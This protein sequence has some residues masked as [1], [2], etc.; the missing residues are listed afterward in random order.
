MRRRSV[1]TALA[2]G[3]LCR[4]LPLDAKAQPA[5]PSQAVRI[6][7]PFPAGGTADA[8]PRIVA[9]ALRPVWRQPI[10]IENRPGAGGNIGAA[11]VATA[12]PDGHTLLASPPP[13]IAISQHLYANIPFDASRLRAVS[14]LASAPNV[15][16]VSIRSGIASLDELVGRAKAEPGGLN[17]ANQGLGTTSHL[18]AAL[19]EQRAGVRFNHVPYSGTAPAL[20]DLI[21]GHVDVF[22]DNIASSLPHHLSGT[23]RILAVCAQNRA[24]QLPSVPT[25]AEI[26]IDGVDATAWY[27]LMA[28]PGTPAALVARIGSDVIAAVN[29][30]AV[31]QRLS[32][33][34]CK[35]VGSTPE[36]A[37]AFIADE[38]RRWGEVV[39]ATGLR[40]RG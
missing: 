26:G 38:T 20:N 14:I 24:D 35:S 18:T 37:A 3:A 12:V 32:E 5:W 39:R 7:V 29:Q 36:E 28:P 33:Q 40:V 8:V 13:P 1:G 11:A 6:V 15:V 2:A 34:A 22:F 16:E 27:A 21:A 30:P 25:A 4:L 19:F 31:L 9:E 17:A 23:L 10:V